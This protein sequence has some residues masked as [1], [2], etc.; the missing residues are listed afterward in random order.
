MSDRLYALEEIEALEA[1]GLLDN[2][3]ATISSM[4]KLELELCKNSEGLRKYIQE[5]WH[6]FEMLPYQLCTFVVLFLVLLRVKK[7][8]KRGSNYFS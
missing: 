6:I 3:P 7:Y 1:Q 4:A 8:L 2:P 5:Q